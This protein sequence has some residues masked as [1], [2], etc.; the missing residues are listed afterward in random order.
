M[1]ESTP[2]TLSEELRDTIAEF[3]IEA[4]ELALAPRL[5]AIDD[6]PAIV[7]RK[8]VRA[9]LAAESERDALRDNPDADC[10]DAAHPAWWR[11]HDRTAKSLCAQINA[12]LDGEDASGAANEPWESTRRRLVALRERLRIAEAVATQIRALTWPKSDIPSEYDLGYEDGF[13]RGAKVAARL[14]ERA[15]R[16]A[17]E[18]SVL[19][20]P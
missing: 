1:S 10:T 7:L 18:E 13:Y 15:A 4:H 16:D 17:A 9:L 14:V 6:P 2:A 5:C 11:G 8:V 20:Q 19:P 3:K 12:I